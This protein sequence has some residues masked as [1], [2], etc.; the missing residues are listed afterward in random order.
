MKIEVTL[1][2]MVDVTEF[3]QL[4]APLVGGPVSQ[5]P[6]QSAQQTP[7]SVQQAGAPPVQAPT[8]QQPTVPPV[9]IPAPQQPAQ[10]VPTT[11]PTYTLDDLGRAGVA[12]QQTGK[13]AEVRALVSSFGVE[14]LQQLP[15]AQYGAF[16]TALRSLGAPI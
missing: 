6:Q 9:Q 8:T 13:A 16:A 14:S 1:E 11:A 2:S 10:Q 3:A 15:E 7:P 5:P 4:L 12:L